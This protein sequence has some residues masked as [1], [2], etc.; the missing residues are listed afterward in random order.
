MGQHGEGVDRSLWAQA[1]QVVRVEKQL[2]VILE[3]S[4]ICS[5]RRVRRKAGKEIT[6]YH[7]PYE[8]G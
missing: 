6:D 1:F 7:Q 2:I 4:G 3:T 5:L 8:L